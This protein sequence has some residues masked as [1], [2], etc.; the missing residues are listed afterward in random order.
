MWDT[1]AHEF[2]S[3]GFPV[4]AV[5]GARVSEWGGRTLSSTVNSVVKKNPDRPE[6]QRLRQWYD[7]HSENTTFESFSNMSLGG[8]MGDGSGMLSS[9]RK[10]TLQQAKNDQLGS[11]FDKPDYFTFKGTVAFIKSEGCAYPACP[12]CRK[13]V[14]MEHSGWRCEKCQKTYDAPQWKY[15]MTANI[16]DATSQMFVS[17]FDETGTTIMEMG[18]GEFISLKENNSAAAQEVVNKALYK[19]YNFKI[20]AKTETFNVSVILY[21]D[22]VVFTNNDHQDIARIKYQVLETTPIDYCKES[23]EMVTEIESLLV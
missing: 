11:S 5:K 4:L 17:L 8:G 20:R 1:L 19:T 16:E 14:V 7:Q 21:K 9:T 13:K 2:D 10:V 22:R 3:S 18:A 6:A 12:E 15:V 23:Q